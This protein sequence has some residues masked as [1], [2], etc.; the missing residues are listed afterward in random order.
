MKEALNC[1]YGDGTAEVMHRFER[2]RE[3]LKE[4]PG[5]IDK[6]LRLLRYLANKHPRRKTISGVLAFFRRQRHRMKYAE[7]RERSLPDGGGPVEAASR[8]LIKNRRNGP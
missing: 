3:T 5:G 7:V 8:M 4:D 1:A 6:V 2:L